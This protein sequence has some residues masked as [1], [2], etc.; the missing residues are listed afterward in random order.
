MYKEL[1]KQSNQRTLAHAATTVY[2]NHTI[3]NITFH[4]YR[5]DIKLNS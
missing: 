4:H 5:T 3:M 2:H 1:K